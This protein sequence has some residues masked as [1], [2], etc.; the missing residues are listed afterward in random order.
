M[1][2]QKHTDASS[3]EVIRIR[4]A[5]E[6]NLQGIDLD[7]PKYRL[8][9]ITGLSGSGKSSLAFDTLFRE[10]QRRFLET[11]SAY[12][13][14][15]LGR[16]EKPDVESIE[17]LAP[18]IAVDQKAASSSPRSTVGTLTEIYDHLRVLFARAAVPYCP[19]CHIALSAQT[20]EGIAQRIL[21]E[22]DGQALVLLSP[23]VRDRKGEHTAVFEDLTRRGLV[24][25]RVDGTLVRLEEVPALDRYKRHSIEAVIDRFTIGAA[26]AARLRESLATAL[27]LGSGEVRVQGPKGERTFSTSRACPSCKTELPPLEPRLFS[28][29]SPHGACHK[30]DG[31]GMARRASEALVVKDATLSI[32]Q[33]ALAVTRKSGGALAW[34]QVDFDFL[35]QVARAHAFDLDTPW[36]ALSRAAKKVILHGSGEQRFDDEF[37]WNGKRSQGSVQWQRRFAGVLPALEKASLGGRR[38]VQKFIAEQVCSACGGTRLNTAALAVRLGHQARVLTLREL[39]VVPI[40]EL[41]PCLTGLEL[42]HSERII[43]RELLTEIERRVDF[44]LDVGLGY[45][46]LARGADTLSGGEAQRI[47]LAAQLSGGLQG[48]LY[49]LDEP[50]IGLHARDHAAML[51]ALCA[52]RDAGNSVIVVEHDEATLRAADWIVDVG[53]LAGRGGGRIVAQGTPKEVARADSPTGRFLRGDLAVPAPPERR[54]GNGAELV[55]EGARAFHLKDVRARLPLGTLIGVAGVSGSGKS[56]LINRILMPAVLRH[57]GREAALP[58]EHDRILGLEHVQDIVSIDA[59]PIGRTPRSNPATYTDVLAPVRDLFASLPEARLRGFS[60][61]RFSFNVEGGRCSACG[62]AGARL[63][64][65]QFL[66]PVTVP[67][68]ECGGHRFQDSTL[69]VRFKGKNIAEVLA[70]TVEDALVHFA[71]QKK[72]VRALRV[73][74]QVGLSYL[75]LGQPSTT[76]SG[77]E[78]QRIKLVWHLARERREHTLYLLDEPTTGL[79]AQDV[80]RLVGALQ[81]LVER[82]H[83]VLVIE[84]NLEVLTACD[85]LL[86]LGPEGGAAGGRIVAEGTPEQL[87][88]H[89]QTPTGK[90]LRGEYR[91]ARAPGRAAARP[92]RAKSADMG[93]AWLR[94]FGARQHNLRGFDV[95][96]PRDRLSVIT[97]PSG[98]GKSSLA[99]DTIHAEGRRR[100]VESLSTYAR[101]FLGD[102]SR[103]A[104]DRIDGLGPSVAVEAQTSRGHP[105]STVA[106]TTEI[107]DH[108][109]VLFARA[110]T[111]CCPEHLEV[112]ESSDAGTLARKIVRE[113]GGRRALV[114]AP[115]VAARRIA[116]A[117]ASKAARARTRAA[118]RSADKHSLASFEATVERLRKAGFL[119]ILVGDVEQRL[120]GKVKAPAAGQGVDLV[121]DRLEIGAA[122][123][124]RLAEAIEQAQALADGRIDVRVEAGAGASAARHAYSTKGACSQCG[125]ALEQ[126]LEARHFSF[127]THAGACPTCDGLGLVRRAS[128][129]KLIV[130]ANQ[131]LF[132]GALHPK[133]GRYLVKGQGFYEHL[134]RT[135]ARVHK[136]DLNKPL[137]RFTAAQRALVLQGTGAQASYEVEIEK[138]YATADI[139]QRFQ[140]GWPGLCGHIDAWYA[141]AEDPEW[142]AQLEAVCD[143]ERCQACNG[144]RLRPEARAVHLGGRRMPQVL[145][146]SVAEALAWLR[147]LELKQGLSQALAPV[148]AELSSRLALLDRVGLGY[149]TMDRATHTL[150]GGE[151]RRVRLSASLGSRLTGVCYVLD[152]PTVGLHPADVGKLTDALLEL[153]DLGNTVLVVEHDEHVIARA[154]HVLDIGPGSGRLGGQV[155]AQ[156]TPQQVERVPES[157]TGRALR[158]EYRLP[159]VP[160]RAERGRVRLEGAR[161]NN[162]KG[163]AIEFAFGQLTGV[164]GASGSGKSTLILDVLVPALQSEAPRERWTSLKFSGAAAGL[165]PR[166]VVVD[167]APL[168]RTPASTPA[169]YTGLLEPLRELFARTTDARMRGLT[170]SHFS[171]NSP[172]GRC[173]ACEG[174]GAIQV[175]MHFLADVWLICEE[176]HGSRY[177]PAV[178][179]ARFAGYNIA[180]VLELSVDQAREVFAAQPALHTILE[181]LAEVGLGYLSLGQSSTTLSGGEA[182][183]VK[184]A[185]ELLNARQGSPAVLVLDEPTTGL[186]ACDV[187]ALAKVLARLADQGH[188]V[189]V[190]EHHAQ[191]LSACDLLIELGPAGGQAG[192]RVMGVG[193]PQALAGDPGSLTGPYLVVNEAKERRAGTRLGVKSGARKSAA[194]AKEV[195]S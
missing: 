105:R 9:A 40:S 119:R 148:L 132:E 183:R 52:L 173:P 12:A 127:N 35:S 2:T 20:P 17:G 106:T 187:A 71:D 102:R 24:R 67:C 134:L 41:K 179:E 97:G 72:I 7:L 34:P 117:G 36:K 157:P 147:G 166:T 92:G 46:S 151:A 27:E 186:H 144:E 126:A 42:T 185:S 69:D 190:I 73:L 61:S 191:L 153:R 87:R 32:R 103:P 86:E 152:E 156:G 143:Q 192:G 104:V 164:C 48:V 39:L 100:F 93:A 19:S 89:A 188:A 74:D 195:L 163:V 58:L 95:S 31:L 128:E 124:A 60:K 121:V 15:F 145:S 11:L 65:L 120:D 91:P 63:V 140:A 45:L 167:A 107:H 158:G 129:D 84:H 22:F 38:E 1:P 59:A 159:R 182:Q 125:F 21:Q 80:A 141:K 79:H 13:R 66:A 10:G 50:S 88:K 51:S 90:A 171:F 82:G 14:Q 56:T 155:V 94:V 162:L 165:V 75:T 130:D 47:R 26:Q 81:T 136:I 28:F 18:A 85:H 137:S 138:S 98:S 131:T 8:V 149:L 118:E 78:A 174:R 139:E 150:S 170:S 23:I 43:A 55:I 5:R 109:R 77:G 64:E 181:S 115:L 68:E 29:N 122:T 57:L 30:C 113:L 177:S 4:G 184:L 44:L 194:R 53:P 168:G 76:L 114:L 160:T 189:L 99:L 37:E 175:E 142:A 116:Q 193:T 112:L 172:R 178:L 108:L 62:G 133:L 49:V 146:D 6:H 161:L 180:Q 70:M 96:L 154:D 135:V 111:R 176:C 54:K 169:T 110:G 33:G 101:Q 16:M 123:R 25:A 83:T 3:A